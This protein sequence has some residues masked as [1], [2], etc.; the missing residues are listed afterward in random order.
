MEELQKFELENCSAMQNIE[1][2][3]ESVYVEQVL[4]LKKLRYHYV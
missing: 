1:T 2:F 4:F 3:K